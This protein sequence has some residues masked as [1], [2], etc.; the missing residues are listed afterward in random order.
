MQPVYKDGTPVERDDII[1]IGSRKAR[2]IHIHNQYQG[3]MMTFDEDRNLLPSITWFVFG[4][5]SLISRFADSE[6]TRPMKPRG[7][8]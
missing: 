3:V 6:D 5:A 8:K 1:Q 2:V 4:S 7:V